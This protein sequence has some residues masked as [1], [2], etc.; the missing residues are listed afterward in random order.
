MSWKIACNLLQPGRL[1]RVQEI[2]CINLLASSRL[3]S[4]MF[5]AACSLG[6]HAGQLLIGSHC[7]RKIGVRNYRWEKSGNFKKIAKIKEFKTHSNYP[8]GMRFIFPI[9]YPN[10]GCPVFLHLS[11]YFIC[12]VCILL[13]INRYFSSNCHQS[14]RE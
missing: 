3:F 13:R 1:V 7:S 5:T 9:L 11:L 2:I 4:F 8:S 14:H 12:N 10:S 6:S